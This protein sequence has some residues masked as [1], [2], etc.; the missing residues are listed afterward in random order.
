MD[1]KE[2]EKT[3]GRRRKEKGRQEQREEERGQEIRVRSEA[4]AWVS[5]W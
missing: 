5:S 1:G 2:S 4:L 3:E